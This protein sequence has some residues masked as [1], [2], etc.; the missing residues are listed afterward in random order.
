MNTILKAFYW[1]IVLAG[2]Y[3]YVIAFPPILSGLLA[4]YNHGL[5]FFQITLLN[6]AGA[7]LIFT[8]AMK[9]FTRFTK[10]PDNAEKQ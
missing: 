10:Q 1:A 9:V 2:V 7:A 8:V 3:A 5:S 6:Y 4:D